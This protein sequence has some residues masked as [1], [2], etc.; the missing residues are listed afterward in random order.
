MIQSAIDGTLMLL[1]DIT[2]LLHTLT[3]KKILLPMDIPPR[4]TYRPSSFLAPHNHPGNLTLTT[5]IFA[6]TFPAYV[7]QVHW[8]FCV[9]H[10]PAFSAL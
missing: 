3:L 1:P 2:F 5:L 4:V 6:Y 9:F 10:L 8:F 7:L